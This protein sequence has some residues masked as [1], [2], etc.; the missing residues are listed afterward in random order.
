MFNPASIGSL[1]IS[2]RFIRSATAE[3][4]ANPDGTV[5]NVYYDHSRTSLYNG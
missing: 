3:F 1:R 5:T 4:A 2:N